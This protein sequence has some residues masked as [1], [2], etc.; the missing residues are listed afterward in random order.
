MRLT[1]PLT[2]QLPPIGVSNKIRVQK[3]SRA[4]LVEAN[5]I[6]EVQYS[7]WL[8]N[9]GFVMS[10]Q[11]IPQG[12]FPGQDTKM[13]ELDVRGTPGCS[14]GPL[15]LEDGSLFGILNSGV[16]HMHL[17]GANACYGI[18]ESVVAASLER[19]F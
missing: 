12:I 16:H 14:G 10:K 11:T 3:L 13:L 1:F 7:K 4:L 19:M 15:A 5:T 2:E 18:P 6:Q 9:V 17:Q 8:A